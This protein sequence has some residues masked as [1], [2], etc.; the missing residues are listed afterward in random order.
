MVCVGWTYRLRLPPAL[1]RVAVLLVRLARFTMIRD[2]IFGLA[3]MVGVFL[4][5]YFLLG[6]IS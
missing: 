2:I 4:P 3:I 5:A 1:G 6:W